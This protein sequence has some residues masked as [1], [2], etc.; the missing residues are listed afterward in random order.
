MTWKKNGRQIKP[1]YKKIAFM[2]SSEYDDFDDTNIRE[3]IVDHKSGFN[4]LE[5][6]VIVIISIAFGVVIGSSVSF[7]RKD[8][9]SEE[10]SSSL[11][12]LIAV[13]NNIVDTYY[14][15]IDEQ[16]LVDAA[17][18]GM[19]SSLDDPYST[20]MD[21]ENSSTFNESVDGSYHGIG[22]T[23][24]LDDDN[25]FLI[26]AVSDSSP[27][28][29][30][31]IEAG[32]ILLEINGE[33]LEGLT[34]DEVTS[35]V[36]DS[37]E[38]V[39]T[40]LL[41]RGDEEIEKK[42]SLDTIDLVSVVSEVYPLNNGNA[43]YIAI[44]NFAAN[45]YE[46]FKE[47]LKNVEKENIKSLIIDVRSNPG[48]HVQQTTDILELFMK[49]GKVLYQIKTKDEVTKIKDTT[50]ASRSYPIVILINSSSASASEILA[51]AFQ[52]SYPD[53][54]LVGNT[55]YG[56]GTVQ[57]AYNLSDGTS[58]KFT[59]EKW[60]TPNGKWIDGKGITPDK[61]VSLNSEYLVNPIPE[62]DLQLQTALDILENKENTS[63]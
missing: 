28:K 53:I 58:V 63:D 15:D 56:K 55:T 61:T 46:Q 1:N 52:D 37:S 11:R 42:V 24:M 36:K 40:L 41:K 27:A 38:D 43:G 60:L 34:L 50:K 8:Y 14:E 4:T 13:Y 51:A 3:V 22:V 47:E 57:T 48:G 29:D 23:L 45:T 6:L 16:D 2:K 26:V 59:T 5:V 31:G 10:I 25:Q 21:E 18:D 30:A 62:N 20:Y 7:F 32:D 19:L 9:Q 44:N 33:T 54:T 35:K 12:E 39:I 49:K 17:V